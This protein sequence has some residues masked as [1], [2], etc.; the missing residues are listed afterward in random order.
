MKKRKP[1]QTGRRPAQTR[2]AASK[3]ILLDGQWLY[4]L[5][6][7]RAALANPRRQS[8]RLVATPQAAEQLGHGVSKATARLELTSLQAISQLLP[9]GAVHQGVALLCAPLPKLGLTEALSLS[10]AGHKRIVVV[11]DQLADPQN[12]GAIF[13]SCAAFDVAAIVIQDRY[14]PLESGALAK[15]ASGALDLVPCSEVVNIARALEE[16]GRMGFW[17][18]GLAGDGERILSET[19]PAGDTAIVLGAEGA[20]VRRLVRE[21]CDIT[22]RIPVSQAMESLNVSN[23]AAIALYELRRA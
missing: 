4:G 23:A 11:L 1:F 21:R 15:A 16:L 8:R 12:V 14:A 10:Q 19:N 3:R 9:L 13:R 18:I 20:G 17:R 7:V 22:A 6:T 5:H 2:A